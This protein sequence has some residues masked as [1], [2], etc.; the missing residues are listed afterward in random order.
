MDAYE[1][2]EL[3]IL[4]W[5]VSFSPYESLRQGTFGLVIKYFQEG[6]LTRLIV[7][8]SF[9]IRYTTTALI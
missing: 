9:C 6:Y 3:K 1:I 4:V 8:Y 5:G 7:T 2:R